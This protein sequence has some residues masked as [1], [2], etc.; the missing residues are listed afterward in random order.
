[1]IKE[2][3]FIDEYR[4]NI[5]YLR[6]TAAAELKDIGE[7]SAKLV[8]KLNR[9]NQPVYLVSLEAR[10]HPS[11]RYV[12]QVIPYMSDLYRHPNHR[13]S[14]VLNPDLKM[15]VLSGIVQQVF[16]FRLR[17]VNSI[18]AALNIIERDQANLMKN[19]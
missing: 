15:Q 14:I 10:L 11:I 6:I 2:T 18:D 3:Y 17:Y 9:A 5:F 13:M 16:H 8:E 19:A 7:L 1:M 4:A 12:K